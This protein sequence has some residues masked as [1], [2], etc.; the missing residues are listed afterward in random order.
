MSRN[1]RGAGPKVGQVV[2]YNNA[3]TIIPGIINQ[4]NSTGTVNICTFSAGGTGTDRATVGYSEGANTAS[5][6][7]YLEFF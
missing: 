3:G 5:T 4:V 1:D 2:I 6:W 7:G